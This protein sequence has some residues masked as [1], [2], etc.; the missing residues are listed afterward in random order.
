MYPITMVSFPYWCKKIKHV[1]QAG[2]SFKFEEPAQLHRRLPSMWHGMTP[3]DKSQMVALIDAHDGE[4][5]VDLCKSLHNECSITFKDQH[6]MCVAYYLAKMSPEH[7][8]LGAPK[9]SAYKSWSEV[10]IAWLRWRE[11]GQ[12]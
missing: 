11:P 5:S 8:L 10:S 3:V 2:Q 12:L 7:M 9:E 4:V 1:L 6:S